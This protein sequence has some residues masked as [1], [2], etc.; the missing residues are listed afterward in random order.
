MVG[1]I[2]VMD[3]KGKVS[4]HT[5]DLTSMSKVAV[6]HLCSIFCPSK[7]CVEEHVIVTDDFYRSVGFIKGTNKVFSVTIANYEVPRV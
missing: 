2:V 1:V 4:M 7:E 6:Q 5:E 3:S